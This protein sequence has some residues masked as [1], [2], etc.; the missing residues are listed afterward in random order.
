MPKRQLREP[1]P[2]GMSPQQKKPYRAPQL[3]EYGDL[4]KITQ[5]KGGMMNDSGN[6]STRK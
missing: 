5:G 2:T 4:Q 1:E 6:P 3:V